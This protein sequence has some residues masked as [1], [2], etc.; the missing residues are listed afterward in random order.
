[1]AD[2]DLVIWDCDGVLV[3]SEI[4]TVEVEQRLL[5]EI[6]WPMTR[7]EVIASFMGRTLASEVAEIAERLGAD[8]AHRFETELVPTLEEV[9]E[10][11]LRPVEGVPEVLAALEE[12]G[13]ACC[14][15]SSGTPTGIRRKLAL[16]GLTERFGDRISSGVEVEHGK[17]APD[18]FLLAATRMGVDPQRCVVLEDSVHGVTGGV[19][20]GMTVLGYAG[21]LAPAA[22]LR[23]AGATTFEA[24]R[25]LTV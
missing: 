18:L 15:A 6:G 20:A 2:F 16:T 13:V 25:D 11:E 1:M 19:A 9:F 5:A 10:R 21:G 17:P 23:A 4:L 3:D 7:E 22:E 12:A 14:V 8:A 24:M